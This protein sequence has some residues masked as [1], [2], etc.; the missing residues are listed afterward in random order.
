MK[1]IY[2]TIILLLV[3]TCFNQTFAQIEVGNWEMHRGNEE[4][5]G[6]TKFRTST[7][8]ERKAAF[9]IGKKKLPDEKAS[10]WRQAKTNPDGTVNF[11]EKSI[12]TQCGQQLD[13]T[14]FQTTVFVPTN[15]TLSNL[16]VSY[17]E[18][19]D[20]ARIYF[21][22]SKY[23]NGSFSETSDLIGNQKAHREVDLKDQI[24]K[25]EHNRI[26]IVQ[27][28]QCPVLN[29]VRGVRIKA[30]G[31]EIK[32]TVLPDKFKL[33][34]YSVNGQRVEKGSN[35]YMAFNPSEQGDAKPGRILNPTKGTVMNIVKET[36]DANKGIIA[37]KVANG[38][39]AGMYLTVTDDKVNSVKVQKSNPNDPKTQFVIRSPVEKEAA[40][41]N[42]V[43]FESV[44]NPNHYLRHAGYVLM[45]SPAND[46][47][48]KNKV[49]RQDASWL[50]E[51]TQ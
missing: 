26:V 1:T 42:F 39:S 21:F 24:V 28:D 38:P 10:G 41:K 9:D 12:L 5:E 47:N 15:E 44:S 20:G 14:Y 30:N 29:K 35:Y 2:N 4:K 40:G 32:P 27:Y 45:V 34:A 17:D 7:T 51:P 31:K 50:F 13:F 19:D 6:P 8:E 43:S 36:V 18:G 46:A 22:N 49:Y 48:F 11:S 16:T 23:P 33:H 37:L 3:I 25:G